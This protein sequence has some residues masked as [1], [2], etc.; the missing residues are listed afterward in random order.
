MDDKLV[1]FLYLLMRDSLPTGE[2]ER[3]IQETEH[4]TPVQNQFSAVHLEAY[5]RQLASRLR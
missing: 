1:A 5:A 3:L 4:A 2:V